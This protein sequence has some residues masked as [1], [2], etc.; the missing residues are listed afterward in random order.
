MLLVGSAVISIGIAQAALEII[1]I[2]PGRLVAQRILNNV[3]LGLE[4]FVGAT[5]IN[6]ILNPSWRAVQTTALTIVVRKL[7]TSSL[8]R[9]AQSGV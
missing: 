8:N 7:V 5:I 3:A 1:R 9:L 6:L 2:R 4:F